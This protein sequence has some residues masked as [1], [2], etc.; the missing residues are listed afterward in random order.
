M[1]SILLGQLSA[2]G[3]CFY[4]TILARQLRADHPDAH[5][6]WAISSHCVDSIRNNPHIDEIWEI[7][8]RNRD[9]MAEMWPVF[10]H[11]AV[12]RYKLGDFDHVLLPQ[13][14]P[15]NFQ[16]YDGTVRPSILRSY[17][18]PI[19]VPIENVISLTEEEIANVERFAR[20]ANLHEAEHVILFECAAQSGQSFVTPDTAQ[21]IAACLY[22]ILP[23]AIC[24]FSTHLPMKLRDKRSRYAGSLSLRET[25][26]LTHHCKLFVGA[27]SGGTVAASSTAS[28]D[29]DMIILLKASTSVYASFAHDFEYFGIEDRTILEMTDERPQHIAECIAET[30]RHGIA[31]AMP[32]FDSRI[33]VR[34]DLYFG[35]IGNALLSR[36]RYLDAATSL[37]Y[38]GHRYGWTRELIDFARKEVEANLTIDPRWAFKPSRQPAEK[39]RSEL[40]RA[41]N[42]PAT[43]PKQGRWKDEWDV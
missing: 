30:C 39:L 29:I 6:T 37:L 16:N 3:D 34:F 27:G 2:N 5:I 12:H 42:E 33:P 19:T 14:A 15:A 10:E 22:K 20:D 25:A 43:E 13:I 38:T 31:A 26:H 24:V 21:E 28:A 32:T 36:Y 23:N 40:A 1:D 11:E 41:E 8:I 17:G 7:P 4:A 35:T 18:R 9:R